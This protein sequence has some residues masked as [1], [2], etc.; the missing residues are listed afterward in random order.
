MSSL[1]D[2][3]RQIQASQDLV[4]RLKGM[5]L[6][7]DLANSIAKPSAIVPPALAFANRYDTILSS[8]YPLSDLNRQLTSYRDSVYD[9]GSSL[10]P[11]MRS[12]PNSGALAS[13][14]FSYY[15][16]LFSGLS[17][18]QSQYSPERLDPF[19]ELAGSLQRAID[20]YTVHL[21]DD[22]ADSDVEDLDTVLSSTAEPIIEQAR[23]GVQLTEADVERIARRVAEKLTPVLLSKR[24]ARIATLIVDACSILGFLVA[25]YSQYRSETLSVQGAATDF[26][27]DKQLQFIGGDV[28]D[29]RP[30]VG[31]Q[32]RISHFRTTTS[33]NLRS[34]PSLDASILLT[35]PT[36]QEVVAA[37]PSQGWLLVSYLDSASC[38]VYTGYVNEQYVT[39]VQ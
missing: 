4:P 36:D 35:V 11:W 24:G 5:G 9:L 8:L 39:P 32:L 34:S 18:L 20:K 25:L 27:Q 10:A 16:G 17:I 12:S 23:N 19:S 3:I 22:T 28:A 7:F 13:S 38:I 37:W 33:V 26:A 30:S 14:I 31:E 21:G 1:E 29:I 2:L 15:T 6:A